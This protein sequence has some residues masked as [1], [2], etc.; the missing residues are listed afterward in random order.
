[1]L[2]QEGWGQMVEE[3]LGVVPMLLLFHLLDDFEEFV[4]IEFT[5]G[6]VTLVVEEGAAVDELGL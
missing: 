6:F 1:M 5:L 2:A 4:C 3:D